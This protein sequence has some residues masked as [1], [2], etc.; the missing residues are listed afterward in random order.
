LEP[1]LLEPPLLAPPVPL[2]PDP[3][4]PPLPPEDLP[5]VPEDAPVPDA[6]LSSS[7]LPH[8]L[9][10]TPPSATHR[11]RFANPNRFI[12]GLQLSRTTA[13]N[14]RECFELY[15]HDKIQALPTP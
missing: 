8:A 7:S 4:V 6:P 3:L 1:P 10:A 2:P 12:S 14:R 15:H 9:I 11:T 5:P 13:L